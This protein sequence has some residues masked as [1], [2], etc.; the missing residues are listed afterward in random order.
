MSQFETS[1]IMREYIKFIKIAGPG[2]DIIPSGTYY[3]KGGELLGLQQKPAIWKKMLDWA[4]TSTPAVFSLTPRAI[5]FLANPITGYV[6][7]GI[8]AAAGIGGLLYYVFRDTGESIG[9][10]LTEIKELEPTSPISQAIVNKWIRDLEAIERKMAIP[11]S[12]SNPQEEGKNLQILLDESSKLIKYLD[13]M[14]AE[15][16]RIA[17]DLKDWSIADIDDVEESIEYLKEH[18]QKNIQDFQQR[19]QAAIQQ[20]MQAVKATTQVDYSSVAKEIVEKHNSLV[21]TFGEENVEYSTVEKGV[22]NFAKMLSEDKPVDADEFATFGPKLQSFNVLLDQALRTKAS[23][24]PPLSKRAL[25]IKGK[26]VSAPAPREMAD[27]IK[28]DKQKLL[29]NPQVKKLQENIN[30]LI[31]EHKSMI[32]PLATDGIYGPKTAETIVV[33]V[34]AIPAFEN[35]LKQYSVTMS[36]LQDIQKMRT[37]AEIINKLNNIFAVAIEEQTKP[38][39]F[40]RFTPRHRGNLT[41]L[42]QLY[43]LVKTELAKEIDPNTDLVDVISF[44]TWAEYMNMLRKDP[45]N[46]YSML[47]DQLDLVIED[48]SLQRAAGAINQAKRLYNALAKNLGIKDIYTI[49]EAAPKTKMPPTAIHCDLDELD[50]SDENIL[51]CLQSGAKNAIDPYSKTEVNLYGFMADRGLNPEQMV[52]FVRRMEGNK[53]PRNWDPQALYREMQ[54]AFSRYSFT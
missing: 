40:A 27:A 13:T 31:A 14:P 52:R 25:K 16:K 49:E 47:L 41:T 35:T 30:K 33:I 11:Q 24:L 29:A 8:I 32:P 4:T 7:G 2:S 18:T 23:T 50:P 38:R 20:Q 51:A 45:K 17:P 10:L 19:L 6:L 54:R 37:D 34:S 21:Q 5:P 42:Q 48:L 44:A 39:L 28:V 12:A 1:E 36:D 46:T 9:E 3:G 43:E 15:L 26:E 22:L 53:Q